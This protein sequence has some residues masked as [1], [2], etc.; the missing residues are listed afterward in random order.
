MYEGR[1]N[2]YCCKAMKEQLNYEQHCKEHGNDCPD[3]V[4]KRSPMG[5]PFLQASNAT[6]VCN[7]CPWCGESLIGG[8]SLRKQ[9]EATREALKLADEVAEL[10]DELERRAAHD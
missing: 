7:Y 9:L 5:I 10:K 2:M 1:N 8:V 4:I 3:V 6:Y